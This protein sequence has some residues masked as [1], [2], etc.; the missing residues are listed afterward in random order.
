MQRIADAARE[1]GDGPGTAEVKPDPDLGSSGSESG[2]ETR[3][4]L[5]LPK[6]VVLTLKPVSNCFSRRGWRQKRPSALKPLL[7]R[8][9]P[10]LQP[11]STSGK[12][13]ARSA[14][15]EAPPSKTVVRMPP[16]IQP[17]PVLQTVPGVP[18]LGVMGGD[19]FESPAALPT[20]PPT[21]RTSFSLSE[22]QVPLSSVPVPKVMLP[23]L[24]P[25]KFRKPY[26]KRRGP[27]RKGAKT[28]LC[29]KSVPLINSAPVIFTVPAATVKV[30]SL[31]SGCNVIQP[32]SAAVAQ[33]PQ[34]I[35]ITTLLVNPTSF[36]CP[37]N[38]S[39]VASS[40]PPLIVSGSSVNLPVQPTPEDKAQVNVDTGCPS[41]DGKNAFQGLVPKSEPQELPPLCATV[42]PKKEHSPGPPA[43]RVC[44]EESAENGAYVWTVVKTEEGRQVVEPLAQGF[45]D[46]PSSLPGDLEKTVKMEPRDPGEEV[47]SSSPGQAICDRIKEELSVELDTGFL[48]EEPSA[49]EAKKQ[50]DSPKEGEGGHP[51]KTPPAAQEPPDGRN[52]GTVSRGSPKNASSSTDPEMA[53]CSPPG[54]PE[55]LSSIEGQSAGTPAAPEAGGEKDGPEEEEE[56]DFDDLT[57]DEEDEMSS[58][59]E[60]SVL[61]VP[62]LQVRAGTLSSIWWAQG[63]V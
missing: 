17:A 37:L 50:T 3:Y 56:E 24:A 63:C 33:S 53:L 43:E 52:S 48:S 54:K 25:S 60:D 14:Q 62:E 39:L 1:G 4:P 12:T 45:Q 38:Q 57:Q 27:K 15:S 34:T 41:D 49:R 59:S 11:S 30:V 51:A 5:L 16:P 55:D 42:F 8:P 32:V 21:A 44:Q 19:S 20:V 35:P 23:S 28:S 18:P 46:S 58:A 40:I 10:S 2:R 13:P 7:I 22:P 26:M 29:L 31:G 36:P 9:S 47:C 6:G 61:S